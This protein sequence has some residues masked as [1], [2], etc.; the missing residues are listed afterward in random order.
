MC[1][2][3][4]NT[5]IIL[6]LGNVLCVILFGKYYRVGLI[7]KVIKVAT[8]WEYVL[9]S[10]QIF[11]IVIECNYL[12]NLFK[13]NSSAWYFTSVTTKAVGCPT[14]AA[15][16]RAS[17]K[18]IV[19]VTGIT[20]SIARKQQIGNSSFT[21]WM[22]ANLSFDV[23]VCVCVSVKERGEMSPKITK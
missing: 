3:I 16:V 22:V 13:R 20:T 15:R 14:C 12:L 17:I 2:R 5:I 11:S 4:P 7:Q 1:R 10:E 19:S 6:F 9:V 18:G 23:C 21:F 8:L